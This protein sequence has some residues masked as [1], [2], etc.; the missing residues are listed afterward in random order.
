MAQAIT[1][2][3]HGLAGGQ[4]A[5][6]AL[7]GEAAARIPTG[8]KIRPG[9]MVL[10][11][12]AAAHP[13]AKAIY[14]QGLDAGQSFAQIERTLVEALPQF[15][16]PLVPRNVPWFTV[17][18]QDFANPEMA[19]Q[20]LNAHGEDRGEGR[21]L[22][23]FPV[24]F[25]S[26]HWQTVM[27]HEL[28]TWA[29]HEKRYWSQYGPDGVVRHCMQHAPVPVDATGR[30]TIRIFGG[31]KAV[32]REENGG[33]CDPE[34]CPEY[35][36]SQCTL[37]GRFLFFM[38]GVRSISALEL[39][40]TSFYAM[41]R[42]VQR[43]QAVAQMRGGRISGFLGRKRAT[44]YLTKV[45]KDVAHIDAQGKAVRRPQWIVELE[46]PID[47][48]ALLR[49][50][51]DAETV[52]QQADHA[53]HV[54]EG[55]SDT[56]KGV[57]Q[58]QEVEESSPAGRPTLQQVLAKAQVLGVAGAQFT[59]YANLRWGRAWRINPHGR[60]RA[61]DEIERYGNDGEGYRDKIEAT[62]RGAS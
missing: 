4:P 52:V 12:Q 59:A 48:T 13:D 3:Q 20:I 1:T 58:H 54:L 2:F 36:N 6:P 62:L 37:R 45:L 42:A 56:R 11:R 25:P 40:T 46:A 8:G 50:R 34:A 18:A 41:S 16:S 49:E 55:E 39:P 21:R 44:F 53:A 61:W 33:I 35:Q 24:V 28:A 19:Q 32:P 22:Y 23:R 17:R 51:E 5:I 7:L 14:L 15:S 9:I 47:V 27:P 29:T 10:T 38:P 26:D 60:G 30:R 43:F 31:R 57:S